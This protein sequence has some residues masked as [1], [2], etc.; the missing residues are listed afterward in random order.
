MSPGQPAHINTLPS[1]I[2]SYIFIT[3]VEGSLYA[4]STDDNS[5]GSCEYPTLISS[6]CTHW[7][8]VSISTPHLWAYIE[9]MSTKNSLRNLERVKLWLERSQSSPLRLRLGRGGEQAEERSS[10]LLGRSHNL[11]QHLGDQLTSILLSAASRAL[12]YAQ[13]LLLGF[14]KG[15]TFSFA[16]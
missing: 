14:W 4:R 6:V 12:V 5:Y 1:E 13:V 7:R 3:L 8:R 11:P 2:S 16:T 9:F 10:R 15:S